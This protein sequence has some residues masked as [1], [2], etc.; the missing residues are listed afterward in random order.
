MTKAKI[1]FVNQEIT[2]Y[3][4]NGARA[5]IGRYLPQRIQERGKK[6]E[7]LCRNSET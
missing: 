6:S 5:E 1:L 4:G 2:P 7:R 3:L